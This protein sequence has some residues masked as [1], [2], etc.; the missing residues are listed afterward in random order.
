MRFST[1]PLVIIL[2]GCASQS[3]LRKLSEVKAIE[4]KVKVGMSE[5]EVF[6]IGGKPDDV[7][8]QDGKRVL[9]YMTPYDDMLLVVFSS[10]RV[11]KTKFV[12]GR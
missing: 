10:D 7:V 9:F 11:Q 2:A 8:L 12:P 6:S 4:S 5:S 3:G 1:V